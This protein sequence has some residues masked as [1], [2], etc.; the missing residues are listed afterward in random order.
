MK[1]AV[2]ALIRVALIVVLVVTP[3]LGV[4]MAME[5]PATGG[6]LPLQAVPLRGYA[7][8]ATSAPMSI[9]TTTTEA[10]AFLL[11]A[12]GI[13]KFKLKR[14]SRALVNHEPC[15]S[16]GRYFHDSITL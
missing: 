14:R 16:A 15:V 8:C 1:V 13:K 12:S 5:T 9:G 7:V 10:S 3:T 11:A 4:S 6:V 2:T